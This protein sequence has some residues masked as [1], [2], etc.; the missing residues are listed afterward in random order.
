MATFPVDTRAKKPAVSNWQRAGLRATREWIDRYGDADGLGLCMGE[1]TLM[2]EVDTDI[3]GDTALAAAL[4]RFGETPITIRTPSGKS[5]AWIE[6]TARAG[7][8]GRFPA[9]RSTFSAPAS[10]SSRRATGRT[11]GPAGGIMLSRC[12]GPGN[13]RRRCIPFPGRAPGPE[14]PKAGR[15]MK[16]ACRSRCSALVG[17][18]AKSALSAGIALGA[19]VGALD[20]Q[21]GREVIIKARTRDQ[22]RIA[23]SFAEA[24]ARSLPE[25]MQAQ[26][27]FRQSPPLEIE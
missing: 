20:K 11:W 17:G 8:S 5:K 12:A 10:P 27:R 1:R 14:D 7:A 6:T 23:W 15:P 18:N 26:S 2:V 19:V 4:E 13:E 16:L 22:A 3:A 9:F 21:P 25:D 24:F